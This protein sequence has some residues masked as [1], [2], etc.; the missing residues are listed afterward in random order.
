MHACGRIHKDLKLENVMVDMNAE[1]GPSSPGLRRSLR[2]ISS[3]SQSTSS[4]WPLGA[5]LKTPGVKLIDFDTV[6]DWS[7][8]SP[9]PR[10]V[11]GTDGYIA[12]EAYEGNYSP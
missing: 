2:Q 4:S 1:K 3:K 9:K 6:T 8:T 5:S 7:P 11:L 12:P 10:E